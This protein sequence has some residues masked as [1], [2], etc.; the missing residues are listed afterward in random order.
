[1]G[2]ITREWVHV[3]RGGKVAFLAAD[4]TT[5]QVACTITRCRQAAPGWFEGSVHFTRD[6]PHFGVRD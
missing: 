5:V 4:G 2:F 6:Q 3:G 1:M